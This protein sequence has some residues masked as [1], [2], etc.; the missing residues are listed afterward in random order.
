ME[1]CVLGQM[2]CT[3]GKGG[4][5]TR[6]GKGEATG[7]VGAFKVHWGEERDL[8]EGYLVE[9]VHFLQVEGDAQGVES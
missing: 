9:K 6:F 7:E 4:G 5:K 1:G 3:Q 2:A 8:A